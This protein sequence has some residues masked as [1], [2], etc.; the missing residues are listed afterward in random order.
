[1]RRQTFQA[2]APVVT[3]YIDRL[4]RVIAIGTE[5]FD[6]L[7]T[8][9]KTA[10]NERGLTIGEFPPLNTSAN[11]GN[12]DGVTASAYPTTYANIDILGRPLIKAVQRNAG[13]LFPTG[14]GDATLTTTYKY[15]V[16]VDS[17]VKTDITV[18]KAVKVGGALTMSR[19]YD[20]GGKLLETSE[21]V[22]TPIAHD[23]AVNYFYDPAANL[24]DIRDSAGNVISASYDDLG[25]KLS[26]NDPDRGHWEFT[27]DGLGRLRTLT[28]ARGI[29]TAYQY[30]ADSRLQRRFVQVKSELPALLN[31]EWQ[32][33][34]NQPGTLGALV[35]YAD[36]Y[37]RE[38]KYDSLMRPWRVDYHVPSD[39][40][41]RW[42]ARDFAVEY[43]YDHNYGR[44][45]ATSYPSGELV[46]LDYDTRGDNIGEAGLAADGTRSATPYRRVTS[47][48]ER[49]QIAGQ[50]FGN[51]MQETYTYDDS[52][53]M[54]LK[55]GATGLVDP[56]PPG[57]PGSEGLIVRDIDYS[58]DQFL[59]LA[60]Q[61]KHFL[62]RGSNNAIQF[63]G[64]TPNTA[65]A[66]E[67]YEY[68]DLQRLIDAN[69]KWQG[70]IPSPSFAADTYSY[71]D[72]GNITSKSDY[73]LL[74]IYGDQGRT[75]NL[76]GPHAV[77]SVSNHGA[78]KAIFK[79]DQNGNMIKGDG[80]EYFV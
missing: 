26:V 54:A 21:H 4:G 58:Y 45:K 53:G 10:Y 5:G 13:A 9:R 61:D 57:C 18:S 39:G 16:V 77:L 31:A 15:S 46:G 7:E 42:K 37:R 47:M 24:N 36:G 23:L 27:Y 33:D 78:V 6:R 56:A 65:T 29:L 74:Y 1:M 73:G 8:I 67:T 63:T 72:L 19:I 51:G 41:G 2:G 50:T 44:I 60:E 38:Y 22:T 52:S 32:Y 59:D 35:G 43:G 79:Y 17:G 64:C 25:R 30:D 76:A 75:T 34:V 40:G 80:R 71:D 70:I 28:D 11:P 68:D 62:L 20:R 14:N 48:S 12:W 55:I 49:G 69:R 3:E 66:A